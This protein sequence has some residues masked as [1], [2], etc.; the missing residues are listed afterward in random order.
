MWVCNP[1]TGY[2]STGVGMAEC[3]RCTAVRVF[4]SCTGHALWHGAAGASVHCMHT[5]CRCVLHVCAV[6]MCIWACMYGHTLHVWVNNWQGAKSGEYT[7]CV[8]K[9]LAECQEWQMAE[10]ILVEHIV[11]GQVEHRV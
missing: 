6:H 3:C 5:I 7:A 4:S 1:R 2:C 8:G 11:C 9:Q 10:P